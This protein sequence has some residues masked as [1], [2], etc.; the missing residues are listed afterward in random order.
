MRRL[1]DEVRTRL[2]LVVAAAAQ[3]AAVVALPPPPGCGVLCD[4]HGAGEGQEEQE[5]EEEE[6]EATPAPSTTS[7]TSTK[8]LAQCRQEHAALRAEIAALRRLGFYASP[9]QHQQQQ[10]RRLRPPLPPPP[11]PPSFYPSSRYPLLAAASASASYRPFFPAR[12][13]Y[14]AGEDDAGWLFGSGYRSSPYYD[15]RPPGPCCWLP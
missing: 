1:R 11:L 3:Q 13:A 9:T 7:S 8:V 12:W 10:P 6:E 14:G 4:S 15:P 2:P 5:K